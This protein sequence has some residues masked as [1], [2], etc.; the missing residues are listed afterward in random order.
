MS[1]S[2]SLYAPPCGRWAGAYRDEIPSR[3]HAP[4][5]RPEPYIGRVL[6]DLPGC[7]IDWALRQ[8]M[9]D[10]RRFR[11]LDLDGALLAHAA[12]RELIREHLLP[13]VPVYSG[14]RNR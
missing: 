14:R 9:R 1:N 10:M 7:S 5:V 11:A 13:L 4:Y 6:I 8:D 12:P 3:Q 2:L